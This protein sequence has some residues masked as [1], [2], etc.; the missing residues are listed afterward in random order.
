MKRHLF[1]KW[2]LATVTT[3]AIVFLCLVL[4]QDQAVSLN[5]IAKT[6]VGVIVLVY[7]IATTYC[8]MLCWQTDQ[9]L[10]NL[11]RSDLDT[12]ADREK[13]FASMDNYWG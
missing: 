2:C 12:E 5:P 6:M 7:L 1:L 3:V 4:A 8:A 10:E 13:L 11:E 9:A